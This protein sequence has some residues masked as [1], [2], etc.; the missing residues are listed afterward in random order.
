MSLLIMA[1]EREVKWQR[2]QYNTMLNF[3]A[4]NLTVFQVLLSHTYPL[5]T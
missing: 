5:F 1:A 3:T 4:T 2:L